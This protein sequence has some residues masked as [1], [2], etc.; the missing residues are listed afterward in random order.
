MGCRFLEKRTRLNEDT[1]RRAVAKLIASGIIEA[2][3]K[4][5]Q[6]GRGA[7]GRRAIGFSLHHQPLRQ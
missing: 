3:S 7:A 2:D 5:G 1:I 4:S 6:R